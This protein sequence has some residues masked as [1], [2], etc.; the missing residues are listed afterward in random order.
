[1][2]EVV[3][4]SCKELYLSYL[5]ES[6]I[7]L[8]G[9]LFEEKRIYSFPSRS[10]NNSYCAA[11]YDLYPR[12]KKRRKKTRLKLIGIVLK[13]ITYLACAASLQL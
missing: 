9:A 12:D 8:R 13:M 4:C 3:T 7:H 10:T 5:W 6:S 11:I 2:A 1:M